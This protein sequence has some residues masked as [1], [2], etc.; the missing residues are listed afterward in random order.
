MSKKHKQNS[1]YLVFQTSN[2][3]LYQ[4][5]FNNN[6]ELSFFNEQL[7]FRVCEFISFKKKIGQLNL[8]ELLEVD[9]PDLEIIHL[10]H[11]DRII[12]LDIFEILELR[13]LLSGAFTMLNL[14]SIIHERLL[15][16]VL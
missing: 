14:N 1:D 2:A 13:E 3:A 8:S 15:R 16:K 10:P 12:A 5:D 11:C 9:S 4:N 6:F 7:T